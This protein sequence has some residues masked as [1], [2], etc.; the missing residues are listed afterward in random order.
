MKSEVWSTAYIMRSPLLCE[1]QEVMLACILYCDMLHSVIAVSKN[2]R[3][4][5]WSHT[6]SVPCMAQGVKAGTT[7][8]LKL[9]C[10]LHNKI[11][12]RVLD[13]RTHD[14]AVCRQRWHR[15]TDNAVCFSKFVC[16]RSSEI[17]RRW[18]PVN[19][20]EWGL[21]HQGSCSL[22][23]YGPG[24]TRKLIMLYRC[25][26]FTKYNAWP[27]RVYTSQRGPPNRLFAWKEQFPR[28]YTMFKQ[29]TIKK[30]TLLSRQLRTST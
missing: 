5:L 15:M 18:P 29:N 22:P 23:S 16:H 7:R 4:S 13:L 24:Q 2:G 14:G 28:E 30:Y 9:N 6:N 20:C 10:L 8:N 25:S 19:F 1:I 3:L 27:L 17:P 26:L 21:Q 12:N 11:D